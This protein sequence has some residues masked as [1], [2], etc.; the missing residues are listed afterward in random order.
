MPTR[1]ALLRHSERGQVIILLI[2]ILVVLLG[3]AALVVDVG[4]AYLIK[5]HLQASA[6]AA[7]TAGALEL[8]DQAAATTF[9]E[10]YSGRDGARND[11][12]K[13]PA[14]TTVVTT[15]CLSF[16]PCSPVNTVVVE[17]TTKVPTI[18]ARVLGID[19][20]TI[21][22]KATACS[23]CSSRP[24]DIMLVLDRTGSMCQDSNGNNDPACTDLQNAR[25]GLR[26]FVQYMDPAIHKI[27]LTVFPPATSGSARCNTPSSSNYN[28]TSAVY[29]VVQLSNDYKIGDNL[30]TSSRLVSTINCQQGG[31]TTAYANAIEHAQ[32]ELQSSRG[33]PGIQNVIIM[34]SDGAA[35]TGPTYYST[36]SP[37]RRRPCAQGVSSAAA[38]K[39]AGT[40]V[41]TIGYDLDALGGGA[42][43]CQ[44]YTG[45]LESPTITAYSALQ[46]MASN[47]E[48]FFNQPNPGDLTRIYTEIAAEIGGTRIIPDDAL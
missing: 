3:A 9:A 8:P 33:R 1:I 43:R 19:E 47:I 39:A 25:A 12:N 29:N 5:R 16:A 15:K 32:A 4:R 7:A 27:G 28:S 38:A 17:Q 18:F 22:A 20:F 37:Y 30:N 36:T 21:R 44:S 24:L 2:V 45:A 34:F 23:P 6:D 46:Q 48:T 42:N 13:L 31:G 26:E 11:N 14:V 40:L 41:Y 10:N 35:N